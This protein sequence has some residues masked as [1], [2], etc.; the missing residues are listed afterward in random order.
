MIPSSARSILR[1]GGQRLL[2]ASRA[3]SALSTEQEQRAAAAAVLL[4]L[5]R[6]AVA[7]TIDGQLE[8]A[9]EPD[10]TEFVVGG[11]G[12]EGTG[13]VMVAVSDDDSDF[14]ERY[15]ISVGGASLT[16]EN[17][18]YATA[19][20]PYLEAT[21][22]GQ[23]CQFEV[24]SKTPSGFQ[25]AHGGEELKLVRSFAGC[26]FPANSPLRNVSDCAHGAG[27]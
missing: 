9:I 18:T 2:G 7:W 25:V 13:K 10:T 16:V 17:I 6:E 4:H 1:A 19:M 20:S 22:D 15:T 12:E 26:S 8:G 21:I 23:E 14:D 11:L 27:G 24:L 3:F 5:D